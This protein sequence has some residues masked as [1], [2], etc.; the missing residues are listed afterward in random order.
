MINLLVQSFLIDFKLEICC[1][2]Y[3]EQFFFIYNFNL[4]ISNYLRKTFDNQNIQY[5]EFIVCVLEMIRT[6]I[7]L[8][9][10]SFLAI[11]F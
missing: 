7:L 4:K 5:D 11:L 1:K 2:R 9:C 6:K 3:F 10:E 8:T